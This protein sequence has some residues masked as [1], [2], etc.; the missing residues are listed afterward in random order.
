[1]NGMRP[2]IFTKFFQFQLRRTFRHTDIGTVVSMTTLLALK[3]N[4]F[5][6]TLLSH[7]IPVMARPPVPAL[8][9]IAD[10]EIITDYND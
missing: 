4:I 9:I 5:S 1:M 8:P 10:Y 3:P 2:F 7:K 6:F